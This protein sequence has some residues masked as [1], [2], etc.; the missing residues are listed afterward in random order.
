MKVYLKR[1]PL[2]NIDIEKYAEQFKIPNFRGVFMKDKLPKKISKQL[3]SAVINLDNTDGVGTHWVSYKK[4]RDKIFYYDSYGNLKP[5]KEVQKYFLSNGGVRVF[6]NHKQYQTLSKM[7]YNCG[8]L[9]LKF[10]LNYDIPIK[11]YA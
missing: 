10:L 2:T 4:N 5:P 8:H 9:C 6:Y 1:R 7:S 3:E 11:M